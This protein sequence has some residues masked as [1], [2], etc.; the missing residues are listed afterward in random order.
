VIP[1]QQGKRFSATLTAGSNRVDID[2]V[3]PIVNVDDLCAA[4]DYGAVVPPVVGLP[5][6]EAADALRTAG[7]LLADRL[8]GDPGQV[9]LAQNPPAGTEI[10][11]GDTQLTVG[12]PEDDAPQTT[13]PE[14]TASREATAA[15]GETC[16]TYTI[17][18]GDFPKSVADRLGVGLES[19][20]AAND[21]TA[22]SSSWL[23]GAVINV[24]CEGDR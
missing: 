21:G 10:G 13:P 20:I 23:I 15:T 24:P 5:M 7:V 8:R 22:L 12:A 6:Y 11:C 18:D 16:G 2:F 4:V 9:V 1:A 14:A 19:L 17:A 3:H